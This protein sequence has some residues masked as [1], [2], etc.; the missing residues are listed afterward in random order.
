MKITH[1]TEVKAENVNDK[2]ASKIK[3]RWLIT[4]EMGAENFAMR[5]FEIEP[6]G[7][8][9]FHS[10]PWEHEVFIIDGQGHVLSPEGKKAF[11]PGD[12]IFIAPNEEHQF[13]NSGSKMVKMLCLI[14]YKERAQQR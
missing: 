10:H 13:I 2:G 5:L 6:G 4:R 7:S 14:P 3:V 9:P 8:S 12:A 1:Y 11:K